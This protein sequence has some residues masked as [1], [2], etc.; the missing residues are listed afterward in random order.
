MA[1]FETGNALSNSIG[2]GVSRAPTQ[3]AS[4]RGAGSTASQTRDLENYLAEQKRQNDREYGL[5]KR[6]LD[7]Q[8]KIAKMNA[9]TARERNEI[10]KWYNEQQVSIARDRLAQEDR[11]F[12]QEFGLKQAQLGYDVLGMQA[13]LRGPEDYFA[14]SN[15]SRG[16]A[17]QPGTATFLNALRDNSKLAAFGAQAGAPD[18]VSVN[19]LSAKLGGPQLIPGTSTAA[20][21]ST[22]GVDSLHSQIQQIGAAGAHKLGAGALE[23]LTD[24]ELKLLQ[25]GLGTVGPDGKAFDVATFMDQYRRSRVGQG[26]SNARAA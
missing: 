21:S 3:T 15:L 26:L 5:K 16:V 11:H 2:V 9:K 7:Q 23:R 22:S 17:A 1:W 19:S 8:Y 24:T 18:A 25:S 14:A 6:D 12:Q 13:Q 20:P 10:D 4:Y